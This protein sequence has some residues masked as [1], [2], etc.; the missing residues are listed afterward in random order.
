MDL[1]MAATEDSCKVHTRTCRSK[2]YKLTSTIHTLLPRLAF[3]V[4][5][6]KTAAHLKYPLLKTSKKE[7]VEP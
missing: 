3:Q 5:V 7:T 2:E 4:R 1:P 6:K